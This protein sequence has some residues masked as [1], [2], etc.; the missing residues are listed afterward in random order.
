MAGRALDNEANH[1]KPT[2]DGPNGA[3][4]DG[5]KPYTGSKPPLIEDQ[6]VDQLCNAVAAGLRYED[7][8]LLAGISRN[9]FRVWRRKAEKGVPPYRDYLERFERA[10][11]LG[12]AAL[13]EH[14]HRAARGE[15]L[16][17]V[18]HHRVDED[19]MVRT[20]KGPGDWRA[21]AWILERR[22][23]EDFGRDNVAVD[24]ILLQVREGIRLDHSRPHAQLPAAVQEEEPT[25]GNGHANG[26]GNGNGNVA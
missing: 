17:V 9:S 11:Q 6:V 14:V 5:E 20:T 3:Y 24:H 23:R 15:Q 26:N 7:A 22:H 21:A 4:K 8:A 12:K 1:N 16:S 25:N 2:Y 18:E 10:E 19:R 13:L